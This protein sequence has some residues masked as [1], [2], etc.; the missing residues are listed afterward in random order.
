MVLTGG[1]QDPSALAAPQ[2]AVTPQQAGARG[3]RAKTPS[4][5]VSYRSVRLGGIPHVQQKP[6]FCGEAVLSSALA[7]A[8]H[9]VT[10]DEVFALTGVDPSL[11]RGA[12]AAELVKAAKAFGYD[13]GR[14]WQRIKVKKA[15]AG[16]NAEFA[17][18]HADL[19]AGIPSIVCTRY[20]ASPKTT[21][22]FRLVVGYDQ[23]K[24]EVLYHEPAE[25]HGGYKRMKRKKLL[26]LWPLKY[27]SREWT[28][29]RLRLDAKKLSAASIAAAKKRAKPAGRFSPADFA[30]HVAR[31]RKK[32]LPEGFALQV[33]EPFVVVGNLSPAQLARYSQGTVRWTVTRLK[34]AYFAKD[35][36]H[37]IDIWLFKDK[38]SYRHYAWKLFKERPSTPYGYYSQTERVLV[39]NIAT[40]GGTL[41]HE[42]VHPFV[43]ANFDG[44]PPWFNEGLGSLYEQCGDDNGRIVGYTNWRLAGLQAA[45][46]KDTVPSFKYLTSRTSTQFYDH[47]PGTNYAQSRYLLYYLQQKRLLRRYYK[48]FYAARKSDPGG[49][50]TLQKVLG[51]KDLPAFKKRWEK[52]V[53]ALRYP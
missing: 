2:Q 14:V 53:L 8:G 41:V 23:A 17:A 24:D 6:D 25:A 43:E 45:I 3:N 12:Y 30:Q 16:L 10:Q 13:P 31:L 32:Q 15:K 7:A 19:R 48:A 1:C 38:K 49:Y 26:S 5:K 37:I 18:L 4:S 28:L 27:D 20:D 21:E 52:W 33:Q 11:G 46:R 9:A 47:D 29:I 39:M 50:A 35:P 22:H 42:I 40:G 51:E 36:K 44:Y 34:Q